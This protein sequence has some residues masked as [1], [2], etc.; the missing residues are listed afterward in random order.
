MIQYRLFLNTVHSTENTYRSGFFF[1]LL[2][3]VDEKSHGKNIYFS[4]RVTGNI[5]QEL[6]GATSIPLIA[7]GGQQEPPFVNHQNTLWAAVNGNN[8][9]GGRWQQMRFEWREND[10]LLRAACCTGS[11]MI[12]PGIISA[13]DDFKQKGGPSSE[14]GLQNTGTKNKTD[15]NDNYRKPDWPA[16]TSTA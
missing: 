10:C 3:Y 16:A 11:Q 13:W 5:I 7:Q 15:R 14:H 4:S 12:W 8:E 1:L 6:Q 9:G 2:P